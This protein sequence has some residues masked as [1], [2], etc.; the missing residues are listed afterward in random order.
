M[1]N[2]FLEVS[3]LY[4]SRFPGALRAP[5][6]PRSFLLGEG[7]TKKNKIACSVGIGGWKCLRQRV[8]GGRG[9][10]VRGH[11]GGFYFSGGCV[12]LKGS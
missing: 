5:T 2:L 3:Y 6:P 1:R 7:S 8:R 9:G 4:L 10:R 11:G 12:L